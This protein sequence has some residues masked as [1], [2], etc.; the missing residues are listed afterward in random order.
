MS[1]CTASPGSRSTWLHA[2]STAAASVDR[3]TV[4]VLVSQDAAFNAVFF[5]NLFLLDQVIPDPRYRR[6]AHGYADEMWSQRRDPR[7]GLF[8]G[9]KSP[10]NDTAPLVEIDALLAGA[11]P[12]A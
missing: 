9:G 3:F 10:L 5:R 8:G 1:C 4:P 6:L 2:A 12:H 7:T 11:E